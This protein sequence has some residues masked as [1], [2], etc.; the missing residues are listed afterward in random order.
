MTICIITT[1]TV[2]KTPWVLAFIALALA[3]PVDAQTTDP[4]FRSWEWEEQP[5]SARA[6][7]LSGAVVASASDAG[8]AV[9]HPA[10]L[11]LLRR[12]RRRFSTGPPSPAASSFSA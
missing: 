4:L 10:S 6:A 8:S 1:T 2:G 12:R 9:L 11:S 3:T 7:G 5:Q